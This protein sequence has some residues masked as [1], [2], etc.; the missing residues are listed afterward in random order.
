MRENR[1]H[2]HSIVSG[3]KALVCEF[4]VESLGKMRVLCGGKKFLRVRK[5][6]D[7]EMDLVRIIGLDH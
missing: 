1:D 4:C 6:M 5:I 7:K 3:V 2:Y